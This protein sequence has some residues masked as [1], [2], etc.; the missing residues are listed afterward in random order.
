MKENKRIKSFKFDLSNTKVIKV[1]NWKWLFCTIAIIF[2]VAGPALIVLNAI[3]LRLS[4]IAN[5]N[6]PAAAYAGAIVGG[7]SLLLA[8]IAQ[9]LV[10]KHR[11][12]EETEKKLKLV[13]HDYSNF[14]IKYH[15][16]NNELLGTLQH[17]NDSIGASFRTKEENT[18]ILSY[19]SDYGSISN[20]IFVYVDSIT[21]KIFLNRVFKN[22]LDN[23][24]CLKLSPEENSEDAIAIMKVFNI[25][26]ENMLFSLEKIICNYYNNRYNIEYYNNNL[27]NRIDSFVNAIIPYLLIYTNKNKTTNFGS[28]SL[29]TFPFIIYYIFKGGIENGKK[30]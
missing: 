16:L 17:S 10:F 20:L 6:S 26:L 29:E 2:L 3:L 19:D 22:Y 18:L 11:E 7:F 24:H 9:I 4:Y 8:G 28:G 12:K 1:K 21:H 23:N 13:E 15:Y 30:N 25:E 14:C 5:P 27:K